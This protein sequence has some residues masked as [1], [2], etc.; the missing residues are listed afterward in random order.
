MQVC[1]TNKRGGVDVKWCVFFPRAKNSFATSDKATVL[2]E[3]DEATTSTF[4]EVES[5]LNQ[6]ITAN[7]YQF[8]H[9]FHKL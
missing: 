9:S 8:L 6:V 2:A 1:P 5:V 4:T 3:T 7:K